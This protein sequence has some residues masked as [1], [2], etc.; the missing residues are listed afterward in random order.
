MRPNDETIYN[1]NAV[2]NEENPQVVNQNESEDKKAS[3]KMI[4]LGA[5]T[6]ILM[7]AGAIYATTALAADENGSQSSHQGSSGH[8]GAAN[9]SA[10]GESLQIAH[11]TSGTS[12]S[13]AFAEARA[14]VGPGGVFHW[15]GGIYNTYTKEEWDALS[16]EEKHDFAEAIK[17]E[18]G[19]DKVDTER[20]S[21]THPRVH[22]V[23][24]A[25]QPQTEDPNINVNIEELHVHY[26]QDDS[27]DDVHVIGYVDSDV[28]VIGDD[29]AVIDN[30]VVD[31]HQAGIVD[32][33]DEAKHDLAFV[34][35]NDNEMVDD[36][37]VMDITTGDILDSNLNPMNISIDQ[38]DS[39]P[40]IPTDGIA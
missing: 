19:V 35:R 13:Q 15:N 16:A 5:A 33:I 36:G 20:I 1:D 22:V 3:W 17:P 21:E 18:Y 23:D 12:F 14:E 31:G 29:V 34:D 27:D 7:G 10:E 6:G 32:F 38:T 24:T 9:G 26:T 28:D 37:E 39:T 2:E 11:P 4:G 40:D 25:H 8:G 30:Y